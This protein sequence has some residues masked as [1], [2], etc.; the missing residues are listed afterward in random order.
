MPDVNE[1]LNIAIKETENLNQG[2]V[3]LVRDLFKGYEWNRISRSERLL[4]GT[5]FLNYVNTSRGSIQAIEKT[6]SG[7]Q[8]YKINVR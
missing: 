3:F 1:L 8:K 7:Q 6:S 4:L 2:E 5:L